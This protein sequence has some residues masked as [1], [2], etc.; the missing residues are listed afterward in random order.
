LW[1]GAS[2]SLGEVTHQ[3]KLRCIHAIAVFGLSGLAE[4][5]AQYCGMRAKG[6]STMAQRFIPYPVYRALPWL[7]LLTGVFTL[8]E[9]RLWTGTIA[10][11][12]LVAAGVFTSWQRHYYRQLARRVREA[13][14]QSDFAETR[15]RGGNATKAP[16]AERVAESLQIPWNDALK[17]GH[18]QLDDQHRRL[19]G[20]A[21]A[22]IAGI[23]LQKGQ[24]AIVALM[25][26]FYED[27]GE[28]CMQEELML[29]QMK[30]PEL[31]AHR[32][33]H[34][35]LRSNAAAMRDSL[36]ARRLIPEEFITF[37]KV[38]LVHDH[39]ATEHFG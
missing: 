21:N 30:A 20:L 7:Y 38:S 27:L 16:S 35:Q 26:A 6:F 34:L 3:T 37:I 24:N 2:T 19:V 32:Q 8:Y 10:G 9:F 25:D 36:H 23:I 29:M 15:S 33:A 22:I 11:G 17:C 14:V 31:G 13:D 4:F 39:I 28:H 18:V 1:Q 12:L 5:S